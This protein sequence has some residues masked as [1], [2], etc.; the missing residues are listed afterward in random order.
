MSTEVFKL[1]GKIAIDNTSANKA[2]DSTANK[3]NQA[4]GKIAAA[5]RKI[6]QAAI[7]SFNQAESGSGKSLAEIAKDSG[8]T[9]NQ[10][11]SDVMKAAKGYKDN[12]MT[13]SDA[14]KK[15]Y[16]DIGYVSKSTAKKVSEDAEE[17]SKEIV[18]H[19]E[20]AEKKVK[21]SS[22][23]IGKAFSKMFSGIGKAAGVCGKAVVTGLGAGAAA[24]GAL[25][26]K[27][28][29]L[30]GELEQNLGGSEAV[31][32][33]W[34][35]QV[36]GS[37]KEAYK[38]MGLSESE[39]LANANKMGALFQGMGFSIGESASMSAEMMQRAADVASI[40]GIPLESAME[41]VNGMAKGNF[42]MMDN[43]GV[44]MNDTALAAYAVEKGIT[45]SYQSMSQ[46]EKIGLAY[47]MFME[48][49]AYAA[50]NYAKEN[51]TLS[52]SLNT[53]KAAWQNFLSGSDAG[54]SENGINALV[55]SFVNVGDVV[56]KNLNKLL[57]KL[58]KG[59]T[60][61]IQR[62]TPYIPEMLQAVLPGLI[63]GA[64]ALITGLAEA[65]PGIVEVL[66]DILP[67]TL[68]Q[69]V[70]S[71]DQ[72]LPALVAAVTS[73]I[74]ALAANMPAILSSIGTALRSWAANGFWPLIQEL[75]RI[76]FGV[77][78]PSW[79]DLEKS[80]SAGWTQIET[81][82]REWFKATFGVELPSW[83]TV[84][85]SIVAWWTRFKNK[86]GEFITA[87]FSLDFSDK[88]KDGVYWWD[89]IWKWFTDIMF[90]LG[91]VLLAAF[92]LD[93]PPLKE[94]VEQIDAW[95]TDI[96]NSIAL[97]L[98]FSVVPTVHAP[99]AAHGNVAGDYASVQYNEEHPDYEL[100]AAEYAAKYAPTDATT[101]NPLGSQDSAAGNTEQAQADAWAAALEQCGIIPGHKNGLDFVP[102][103]N[104][105][106]R[107][108][109]G[110]SVLTKEEAAA[111]RNGQQSGIDYDRLAEA[112]AQR[113]MA[114]NIDGK[115]FAVMLAR[116]LSRS[117][118]NRNIQSMM[119]M[120]G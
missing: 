22:G 100:T 15:A 54:T 99:G 70:A 89:R 16:A 51:D 28:M 63:A 44:A 110:E 57:P 39:Y 120:G 2:I 50:G 10:L 5:F 107:L 85:N 77:E 40:M 4:H 71:L 108:H 105:L 114:F 80:I 60:T 78:L 19:A 90:L 1:E 17:A 75:F 116:E 96:K 91:D 94:I 34:S 58:T 62:L 119:A 74:T 26:V 14:M 87:V 72:I 113:P 6:G 27:S 53:A 92:G 29:G 36:Q 88:D 69:V 46:N 18:E 64:V 9:V 76:V 79:D 25:V 32:K 106:A 118:G 52:G 45:K 67:E 98:G 33:H 73:V 115:A 56:T 37:A 49:S 43:L 47:E 82:V 103:D 61:L 3:A 65:L 48:R 111:W 117:I 86:I 35:A 97:S 42:T 68:E 23:G 20:D 7:D 31:F 13:M 21:N 83:E 81:S 30:A 8:K 93:L 24:M 104:Y 84:R 41:A 55:E 101:Y 109:Y 12:G 59:L 11:K 38:N 66:A 112:M 102:R 95:W